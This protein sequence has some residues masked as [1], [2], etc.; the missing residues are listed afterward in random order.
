MHAS[1]NCYRP[2]RTSNMCICRPIVTCMQVVDGMIENVYKPCLFGE[3]C[4]MMQLQFIYTPSSPPILNH[5]WWL[6]P[7]LCVAN[8]GMLV[9]IFMFIQ[10]Y[11][12]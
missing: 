3:V 5:Q 7:C 1:V 9:V 6:V 2:R 11:Y 12:G 8:S 4:L 10:V